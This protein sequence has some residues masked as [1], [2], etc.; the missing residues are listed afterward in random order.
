MNLGESAL[1]IAAAEATGAY[2]HPTGSTVYHHTDALHIGG[3]DAVALA[4][5]MAD[6]ITVQRALF[7][8]LTKLTHGNPPP[9]W[10]VLHIKLI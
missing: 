2:V 7:A 6:V 10:R 9:Y 3:P 1:H 5:G 8:N 4:V